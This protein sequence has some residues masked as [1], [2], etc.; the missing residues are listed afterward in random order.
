MDMLF[1]LVMIVGLVNMF[2]LWEGFLL[3]MEP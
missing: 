2:F 1:G 3:V